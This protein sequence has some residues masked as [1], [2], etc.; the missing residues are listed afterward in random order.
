V[1]PRF[2]GRFVLIQRGV[3]AL[4]EIIN[5]LGERSGATSCFFLPAAILAAAK[6]ARLVILP[7]SVGVACALGG[8]ASVTGGTGVRRRRIG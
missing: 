8:L 3:G 5:A 6:S 7:P 1:F 4:R 2:Q